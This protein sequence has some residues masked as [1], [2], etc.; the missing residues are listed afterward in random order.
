MEQSQEARR[1]AI[2]HVC[3]TFFILFTH[4]LRG[5][6][7]CWNDPKHKAHDQVKLQ[8]D[9]W[10]GVRNTKSSRFDDKIGTLWKEYQAFMDCCEDAPWGPNVKMKMKYYFWLLLRSHVFERQSNVSPE[11]WLVALLLKDPFVMG[12]YSLRLLQEQANRARQHWAKYRRKE[13]EYE[14]CGKNKENMKSCA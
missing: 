9:K 10:N 4:V 5:T 6:V 13:C 14:S 3:C 12:F 1:E 7:T 11:Q 8:E 2:R